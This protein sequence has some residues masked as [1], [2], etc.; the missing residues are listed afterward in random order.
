MEES[1][2]LGQCQGYWPACAS[3]PTGRCPRELRL[4]TL[5]EVGAG[6]ARESLHSRVAQ[7]IKRD[8]PDGVISK[9][10]AH[11]GLQARSNTAREQNQPACILQTTREMR[12]AMQRLRFE[13]K[14][15]HSA[16][17]DRH[18][19]VDHDGLKQGLPFLQDCGSRA[20]Q[21]WIAHSKDSGIR[22]LASQRVIQIDANR[23]VA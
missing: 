17:R 3:R 12:A 18:V 22:T 15:V 8:C 5:R 20:D 19:P 10:L 14:S 21:T 13:F 9:E 2:Q 4:T 11:P 6:L 23:P 16:S 1:E 7:P